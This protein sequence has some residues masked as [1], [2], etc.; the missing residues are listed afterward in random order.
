MAWV[1]LDRMIDAVERF[2]L[3]GPADRWRRVRDE[4]HREV[5]AR[6]WD[7]ER[8][9]FTQAYDLRKLDAG[10]LMIPL[11]GFLPPSDPRV[12]GTVD[13]V[14]RELC[15]EGLV[16]R[17]QPDGRGSVDGVTGGEGAF[18][19]C[20]FWLADCL[21]LLGR[22]D[23]AVELFERVRALRN[24]VGLLSEQYDP[25]SRRM[26]GNF[27]QA[28]SHVGLVNTAGNL[29]AAAGAPAA[30]RRGGPAG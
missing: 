13:A 24:D 29:E 23:E 21:A 12:A 18:L 3:A 2:G 30:H 15:V 28:F 20:S 16:R 5:C 7:A 14:R 9:T 1:A 11:V 25:E 27:P 6:G 4:I 10:L 8:G 22:R 17:Y 26:L 19:A